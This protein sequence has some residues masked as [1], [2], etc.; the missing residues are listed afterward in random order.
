MA[1]EFF[2][3]VDERDQTFADIGRLIQDYEDG[4]SEKSNLVNAYRDL[5]A[6]DA[7]RTF[8][9]VTLKRTR[10]DP[11][12][13]PNW[14]TSGEC[15]IVANRQCT[16][17]IRR[18]TPDTGRP[19]IY[20]A[21][22][23]IIHTLMSPSPVTVDLYRAD[24]PTQPLQWVS[25]RTLVQNE[26]IEVE[27]PFAYRWSLDGKPAL[28]SRILIDSADYTAVYDAES[29]NYISMLSLDTTSTRWYFMAKL[30][31]QLDSGQAAPLLEQL[32]EHP[33][34]NVR[35]SA[36]QELFNHDQDKAIAIL[37]RFTS[38]SNEFIREQACSESARI[39]ALLAEGGA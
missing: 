39:E 9:Q 15:A 27:P 21:S 28:F 19:L 1:E 3:Q 12:F 34:Y 24:G 8:L 35:W 2:R 37:H 7:F 31:G 4:L 16:L 38:D 33:S 26:S 32:T 5:A 20:S 14:M 22:G 6:T 17:S 10:D 23:T 11:A 36:L 13:S 30:A 25:R 29:L 18:V